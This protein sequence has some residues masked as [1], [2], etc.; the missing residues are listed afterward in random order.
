MEIEWDE[1]SCSRM[2]DKLST[3]LGDDDVVWDKGRGR[4]GRNSLAVR[5]E[6]SDRGIRMRIAGMRLSIV[7]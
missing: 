2:G 5:G 1:V 6:S 7:R 3:L 4:V